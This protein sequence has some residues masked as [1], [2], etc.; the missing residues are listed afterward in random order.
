MT[1]WYSPPPKQRESL[2]FT[3]VELRIGLV[4][5]RLQL[6][7]ES[8]KCNKKWR[9]KGHSEHRSWHRSSKSF[10][11]PVECTIYR[12]V[13]IL[14]SLKFQIISNIATRHNLPSLFSFIFLQFQIVSNPATMHALKTLF[15]KYF[16]QFQTISTTVRRQN[17]CIRDFM[18]KKISAVPNRFHNCQNSC[19]RDI[20]S[21]RK[22]AVEFQIVSYTITVHA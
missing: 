9:P 12:L 6:F 4:G 17:A 3:G 18:L 15:S 5:P 21:K 7:L 19:F 16:L 8:Q 10:K 20:V 14:I 2:L 13:F 11:I 1:L 22:S